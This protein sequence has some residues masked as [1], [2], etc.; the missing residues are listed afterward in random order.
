METREVR[1][2]GERGTAMFKAQIVFRH[3]STTPGLDVVLAGRLVCTQRAVQHQPRST[4]GMI[5]WQASR[6]AISPTRRNNDQEFRT[7]DALQ[8]ESSWS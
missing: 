5:D 2:S 8:G 7:F 4:V 3:L 1:L 6:M